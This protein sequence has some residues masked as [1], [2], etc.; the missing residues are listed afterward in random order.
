MVFNEVVS[1]LENAFWSGFAALG[2]G[3]LFKIPKRVIPIVYF[4]G[5]MA[6]LIKFYSLL[7]DLNIVTATFL[8]AFSVGFLALVFAKRVANPTVVYIIP[9][10]IPMIPGF[11]AY[12]VILNIQKFIFFHDATNKQVYLDHV[13]F[14][15]FMTL[16]ILFAISIGVSLPM[17]VVGKDMTKRMKE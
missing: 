3:L 15:S 16:F 9:A 1:I 6:G 4:L 12:Q 11:F 7:K 14:N 10:V 8:A 5:F 13:F 17:L 2:F